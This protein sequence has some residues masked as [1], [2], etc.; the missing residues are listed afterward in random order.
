LKGSLFDGFAFHNFIPE[1]GRRVENHAWRDLFHAVKALTGFV[2]AG[3]A[4]K[5]NP[6]NPVVAVGVGRVNEGIRRA[7]NH[8]GGQFRE[9][10]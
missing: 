5:V 4:G 10:G 2:A 8:H 9:T 1:R 7:V 3:A 6:D